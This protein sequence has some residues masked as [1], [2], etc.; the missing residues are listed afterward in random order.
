M[1]EDVITDTAKQVMMEALGRATDFMKSYLYEPDHVAVILATSRMDGLVG[2]LIRARLLPCPSSKDDLLESEYGVS[3]FSVRIDLAHRLGLINAGMA[4]ALHLF[5]KIRNAFAHCSQ[6]QSLAVSPHK[7][8][9]NDLIRTLNDSKM[10]EVRKSIVAEHKQSPEKASFTVTSAYVIA[11]LEITLEV[12][13]QVD[14]AAAKIASY[15]Q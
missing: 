7:E 1:N 11:K 15:P 6:G 2:D 4:R 8:R 13:A 12:V 5:R 9:V 3:T 14:A 10:N